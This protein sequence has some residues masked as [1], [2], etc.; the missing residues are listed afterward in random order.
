MNASNDDWVEKDV[1]STSLL[2]GVRWRRGGGERELA[3]DVDGGD[4]HRASYGR[5]PLA[6]R[7][8]AAPPRYAAAPQTVPRDSLESP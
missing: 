4:H 3:Q 1:G 6:R 5:F 7:G 2:V 8:V